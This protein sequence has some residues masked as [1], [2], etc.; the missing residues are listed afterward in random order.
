[1]PVIPA[2]NGG[3]G[4]TAGITAITTTQLGCLTTAQVANLVPQLNASGQIATSQIATLNQNTTG[5]AANV[6]GT[7]AIANGGTGATTQ[8]TALN[9]L[10]GG[11][12]A[13]GS[14][15]GRPLISNGSNV[16]FGT[17]DLT[18]NSGVVT[19]T[20]DVGNGG[21]GNFQASIK[22]HL[23]ISG[24]IETLATSTI[25]LS[26]NVP[27]VFW[28]TGTGAT[29]INLPDM[30]NSPNG[31]QFRIINKG[32]GTATFKL[33]GTTTTLCTIAAG[34]TRL[35][36]GNGGTNTAASWAFLPSQTTNV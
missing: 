11:S 22:T 24:F 36:I 30:I 25:D 20:L 18:N 6:T 33:F 19:G 7:V 9:A 15:I 1:M 16:L 26:E 2:A 3:T 28:I 10:A 27:Q 14:N 34:S 13:I 23:N 29:T 35:L 12:S 17:V 21:T 31:I 4:T 5:T 32:T 8:N